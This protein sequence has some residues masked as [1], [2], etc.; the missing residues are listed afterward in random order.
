MLPVLL[1]TRLEL[2][3]RLTACQ[4]A[5]GQYCSV[6]WQSG[7]RDV[8][9]FTGMQNEFHLVAVEDYR[10][11]HAE[12]VP[13]DSVRPLYNAAPRVALPEVV[14]KCATLKCT[15]KWMTF[16]TQTCLYGAF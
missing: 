7:Q 13:F 10:D 11:S 3:R 6:N 9:L 12:R 4:H 16:E 15:H 1:P 2:T 8:C 14:L 5:S